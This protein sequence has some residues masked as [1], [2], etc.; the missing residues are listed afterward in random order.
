MSD[1]LSYYEIITEIKVC[2][3][4]SVGINHPYLNVC[5]LKYDSMQIILYL[6]F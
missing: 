1:Q 5:R 4:E 2:L 6:L 3:S